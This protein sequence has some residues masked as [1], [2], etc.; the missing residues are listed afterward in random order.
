MV[1]L[2]SSFWE[3]AIR[4]WWR[5]SKAEYAPVSPEH[6]FGSRSDSRIRLKPRG[7]LVQKL[8]LMYPGVWNFQWSLEVPAGTHPQDGGDW[9]RGQNKNGSNRHWRDSILF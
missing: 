9:G 3:G 6:E 1:G 4:T 5:G 7:K 8:V 2:S